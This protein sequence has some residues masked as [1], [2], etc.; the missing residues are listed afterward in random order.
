MFI[1]ANLLSF[2]GVL[3]LF[4]LVG[5]RLLTA[6]G[7]RPMEAWM[8]GRI[9]GML[10]VTYPAWWLGVLGMSQGQAAGSVLLIL[11]SLWGL[12]RLLG[13]RSVW[14]S[15][16]VGELVFV[17]GSAYYRRATLAQLR[18]VGRVGFQHGDTVLLSVTDAP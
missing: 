9:A 2:Y 1:V 8:G 14:R 10:A 12:Y 13:E 7:L 17:L 4:G 5:F 18:Q 11:G 16:L 15:V 3:T 6:V